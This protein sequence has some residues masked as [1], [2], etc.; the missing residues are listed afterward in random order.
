MAISGTKGQGWR[1]IP[2]QYRKASDIL[3]STLAA[4]LTR[5]S[6]C[7]CCSVWRN[8][9][10]FIIFTAQFL[11]T[12]ITIIWHPKTDF[13][14]RLYW[15]FPI[16]W[17]A[18]QGKGIKSKLCGD[19][20]QWNLL[21]TNPITFPRLTN[22]V[23]QHRKHERTWAVWRTTQFLPYHQQESLGSIFQWTDGGRSNKRSKLGPFQNLFLGKDAQ[24]CNNSSSSASL[25]LHRPHP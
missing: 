8:N 11:F 4:F 10:N 20:W 21:I 22:S 19:C 15:H 16:Y 18:L 2:T 5:S 24:L 23:L 17:V 25:L 14:H 6:F 3:T 7:I 13:K 12:T 9:D 1:A